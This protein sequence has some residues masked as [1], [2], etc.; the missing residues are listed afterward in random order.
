MAKRKDNTLYIIEFQ[1]K[2]KPTNPAF[3]GSLEDEPPNPNEKSGGFSYLMSIPQ[4][5]KVGGCKIVL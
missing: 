5:T 1:R 3:G 2:A 4:A